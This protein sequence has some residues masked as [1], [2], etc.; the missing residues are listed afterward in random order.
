[1]TKEFNDKLAQILTD[2]GVYILNIID[3]YDNGLFLSAAVNTLRQTFPHI[4]VVSVDR[5]TS[6]L[7]NFV[8]I[9]SMH[10]VDIYDIA[11]HYELNDSFLWILDERDMQ[12]LS[13]KTQGLVLTDDYAPVENLFAPAIRRTAPLIQ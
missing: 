7:S 13:N 12:T 2:D 10:P 5:P 11:D 6:I 8:S 3:V 1:V 9:C 4:H